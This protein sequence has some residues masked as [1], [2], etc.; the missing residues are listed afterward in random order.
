MQ[1]LGFIFHMQITLS[2]VLK[3]CHSM[4]AAFIFQHETMSGISPSWQQ[5]ELPVLTVSHQS[6]KFIQLDLHFDLQMSNI[7]FDIWL[8]WG[9]NSKWCDDHPTLSAV[10]S[11]CPCF[12]IR[13]P[14]GGVGRVV[15]YMG[16][17]WARVCP[18]K[19][20]PL[21]HSLERLAPCKHLYRF[22]VLFLWPFGCL[23][24][25]LSTPCMIIFMHA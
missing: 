1:H 10:F 4:R 6:Y 18:R 8:R 5:K 7:V 14:V 16:N 17:S 23:L 19:Y 9:I 15:S 22:C 2:V 21:P 13:M 24:W 12:L 3:A 11:L 20:R 25:H